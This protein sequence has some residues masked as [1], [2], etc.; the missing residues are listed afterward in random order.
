MAEEHL[1]PGHNG[2]GTYEHH[3]ADVKLIVYSTFALIISVVIVCL[4]VVAI[5]KAMQEAMPK[6]PRASYVDNPYRIPPEPR[7]Q[8]VTRL[9]SCERCASM[10]MRF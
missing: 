6:A 8:A 3:D 10:R 9:W 7:L 2:T 5:F 4:V 1:Q